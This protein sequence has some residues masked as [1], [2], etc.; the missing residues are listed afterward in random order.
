MDII[1]TTTE[2]EWA[3]FVR[4]TLL[5]LWLEQGVRRA[6]DRPETQERLLARWGESVD[7]AVADLATA[8][9]DSVPADPVAAVWR[10]FPRLDCDHCAA[11][12]QALIEGRAAR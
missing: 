6:A 5:D 9:G 12:A 2:A 1:T 11:L 8:F 7:Q 10:A 3:A 4:D